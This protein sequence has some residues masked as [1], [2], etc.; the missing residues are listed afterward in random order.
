MQG[1]VL[2]LIVGLGNP[3]LQ[4]QDNRHN[5]GAQFVAQLCARYDGELRT[6]SK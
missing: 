1:N 6:E 3:G 4:Y 5:A 2:K